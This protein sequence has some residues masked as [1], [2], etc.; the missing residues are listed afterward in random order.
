MGM[1]GSNRRKP[2]AHPEPSSP[3]PAMLEFTIDS[4]HDASRKVQIA[5]L[6]ELAKRGFN[7][8]AIYAIRLALEEAMQNAIRHGN[9][10]NPKKKVH[11]QARI[12]SEICEIS[13]EDQGVGF[14]RSKVPDPTLDENLEK[15]SGRGILLIERY[16][17]KVDWS[18]GGRRLHMIKRNEPDLFPRG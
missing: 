2:R 15:C 17:N 1:A 5:V 13:V 18:N 7:T 11:I 10:L 12:S 4:E 3:P 8:N 16:M 6:R 9:K 14:D